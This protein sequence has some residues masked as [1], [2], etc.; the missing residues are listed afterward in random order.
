MRRTMKPLRTAG[1]L[2][3]LTLFCAGPARAAPL[4]VPDTLAQRAQAC[5]PC[6]GKEGRA[7]NQGYFPRIA[8]KPAGYLAN[9]LVNFREGRRPYPLMTYLVDHMSDAYIAEIAGYF[10]SLDLPYPPPA[11]VT[12]DAATLARGAALVHEGD[13][14]R[15]IPACIACHG[16]AL[17]GVQPAIPGLLG[18]PRDYV[19]AQLGT[20]K[21]G[22]RRAHAPDCMAQIAARLTPDDVAA[23]SAWLA[24]QPLPADTKPAAILP[25]PLPM[26]C[27][28]VAPA[29]PR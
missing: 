9:Q 1:L 24:S 26:P 11:P 25:K 20:W 10:A 23:A 29:E 22:E 28:G 16:E 4:V 7:T 27:G 21:N 14:A 6:H 5:T 3:A 8:G 19:N 18:L 12:A 17:T 13:A 15:R 2:A